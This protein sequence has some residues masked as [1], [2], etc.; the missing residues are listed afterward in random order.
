LSSEPTKANGGP[1]TAASKAAT[2]CL[3]LGYYP[4]I[5]YNLHNMT[6]KKTILLAT[7]GYWLVLFVLTHVPVRSA[8]SVSVNDKVAHFVAYF[9]LAG[10]LYFA[11]WM[12]QPARR[13]IG[14]IVLGVAMIYGAVDEVLQ[15]PVGRSCELG[16]WLADVAGAGAMVLLIGTIRH[17]AGRRRNA[18]FKGEA[19]ARQSA[20]CTVAD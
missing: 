3:P 9:I 1:K 8:P 2:G 7:A 15:I 10:L 4:Y 6:W 14:W 20:A 13:G 16:D 12:Y 17:V 18:Q 19:N 11:I 5:G